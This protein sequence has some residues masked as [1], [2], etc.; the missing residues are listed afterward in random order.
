MQALLPVHGN[1]LTL[2]DRFI[3]SFLSGDDLRTNE[4]KARPIRF[5][6]INLAFKFCYLVFIVYTHVVIRFLCGGDK[7]KD[8]HTN[9]GAD[10]DS[11]Q[12][13]YHGYTSIVLL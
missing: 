9:L 4:K 8:N 13:L 3:T 5:T 1:G 11:E 10:K 7:S 2:P 6:Q 12:K